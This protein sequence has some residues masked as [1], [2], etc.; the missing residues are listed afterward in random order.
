MGDTNLPPQYLRFTT[1][2]WAPSSES[3][4]MTSAFCSV[5]GV[6]DVRYNL[7]VYGEFLKDIPRRLGTNA[8]LDAS[9][10]AVIATFPDVYSSSRR[11]SVKAYEGYG[12]ALKVLRECLNDPVQ[13]GSVDTICAVYLI[14][15]CQVCPFHS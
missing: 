13:A 9:V 14:L 8:A 15:L 11:R 1:I 4:M 5:L 10:G 7:S 2:T 6:T 12:H 3:T